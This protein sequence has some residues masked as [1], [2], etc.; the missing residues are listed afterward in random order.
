MKTLYALTYWQDNG[1]NNEWKVIYSHTSSVFST[2]ELAKASVSG[3]TWEKKEQEWESNLQ[4]IESK[5]E[6]EG[7]IMPVE[8]YWYTIVPVELDPEKGE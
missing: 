6:D 3:V 5:N 7:C 1:E 4:E 2:V 8:T